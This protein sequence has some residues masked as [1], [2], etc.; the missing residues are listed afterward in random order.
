MCNIHS[1]LDQELQKKITNLMTYCNYSIDETNLNFR[2][3]HSQRHD[4][5]KMK[6]EEILGMGAGGTKLLTSYIHRACEK[7]H[8]WMCTNQCS[9][10]LLRMQVFCGM[11]LSMTECLSLF[12]RITV[13]SK[14][15]K[16]NTQWHSIT[17]NKNLIL[18]SGHHNKVKGSPSLSKKKSMFL[19]QNSIWW[20]GKFCLIKLVQIK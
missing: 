2:Q 15:W 13:P 16:P 9:A 17:S 5:F 20:Q 10:P 11:T 4:H 1:E 14:Q 7:G 18:I 19:Q 12:W 8:S 3:Q 6:C